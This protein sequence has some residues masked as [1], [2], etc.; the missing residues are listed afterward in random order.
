MQTMTSETIKTAASNER[1]SRDEAE[2]AIRTLIEWAGDDPER[3][4]LV[5]TP[6]R[7]AKA[8]EEFFAG[9]AQDPEEVLS[10]TFEDV[11]RY[12]EMVMLRGI[13]FE[14]HCE[15]HIVRIKGLAHV[16][17]FPDKKIVGLSKLARVVDIFARRLQTQEK[18]TVQIAETITNVLQ[19]KGVA[20]MIEAEH[21]CMSCRGVRKQGVR[22][23]TTKMTGLFGKNPGM[24]Q[25]FLTMVKGLDNIGY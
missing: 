9:Y 11:E 13:H 19:P 14:S 22:T 8:F 18:M 7:V 17:Y 5:D 25:E 16:A 24:K 6:K 12:D 1:P 3:E 21:E 15:H 4:G 2:A 23:I 10:R 20:V